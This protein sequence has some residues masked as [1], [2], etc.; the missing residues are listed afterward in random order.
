VCV[1]VRACPCAC[2]CT[3]VCVCVC[4]CMSVCVCV[5]ALAHVRMHSHLPVITRPTLLISASPLSFTPTPRGMSSKCYGNSFLQCT[6]YSNSPF[7]SLALSGATYSPVSTVTYM[8]SPTTILPTMQAR[9]SCCLSP[10]VYS[11]VLVK[12]YTLAG[13]LQHA[14]LRKPSESAHIDD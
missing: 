1:C 3:C 13:A 2:V 8:H 11:W 6:I 9:M 5:C 7:D 10:S 14:G 4:V 12:G